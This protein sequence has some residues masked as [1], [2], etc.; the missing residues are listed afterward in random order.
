MARQVI[1]CPDGT[2]A[3]FSS[4]NDTW[5]ACCGLTHEDVVADYERLHEE[6][7]EG[8][9]EEQRREFDPDGILR[10][11]RMLDAGIKRP[12]AQFTLTFEQANAKSIE[13]GGEDY[14]DTH[15]REDWQGPHEDDGR[16]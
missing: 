16:A 4:Y 12:Y 15:G 2:Y 1:K 7:Q 3:V 13:H 9:P 8:L 5:V 6:L 11:L 10:V 14:G